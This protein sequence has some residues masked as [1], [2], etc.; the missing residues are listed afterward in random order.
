RVGHPVSHVIHADFRPKA[1][2]TIEITNEV[3]YQDDR[4]MLVR[5]H[6]LGVTTH[7]LAHRE[8]LRI[9]VIPVHA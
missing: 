9:E 2:L 3:L 7:F 6:L 8:G 5:S 1:M 4:I